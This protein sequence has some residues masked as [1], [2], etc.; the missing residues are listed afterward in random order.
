MDHLYERGP[1][2]NIGEGESDD[3]DVQQP[4]DTGVEDSGD[5]E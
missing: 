2:V 1:D 4:T 5:D 3:L